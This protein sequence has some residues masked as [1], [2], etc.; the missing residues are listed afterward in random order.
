M[1][2]PTGTVYTETVVYSAPEAFLADAPYQT[3]IISLDAGSRISGR[4]LGDRVVIDDRVEQIET[5]NG[6]PYFR[7][8]Q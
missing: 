1:D 3:A 2:N 4:I 6:I 7:K 8:M 5:R